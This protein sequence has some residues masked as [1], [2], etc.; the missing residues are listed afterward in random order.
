MVCVSLA[1]EVDVATAPDVNRLM[2]TFDKVYMAVHV[3]LSDV[4]FLDTSGLQP[5]IEAARRRA[6]PGL[7]PLLIDGAS[8]VVRRLLDAVQVGGDP[9]LDVAAWDDFDRAAASMPLP[10]RPSVGD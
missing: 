9:V 7:P 1:G 6:A 4:T 3:D 2:T 10:V 5:L 8:R